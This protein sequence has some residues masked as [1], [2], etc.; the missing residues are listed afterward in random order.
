MSGLPLA[1]RRHEDRE[2]VQPVVEV[3]AELAGRDRLFEILVGGGHEP[4]VGP[5]GFRAAQP[6]ELALLQDAQ[7]LH[8]RREVQLADLVEEQRAAFGELE[9]ALSSAP[10]RR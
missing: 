4:H 10:A 1:Q 3:L 2:D 8:L 5:D 6:L 9:A 7:Q